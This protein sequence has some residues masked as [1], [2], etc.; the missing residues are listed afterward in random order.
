VFVRVIS[1]IVYST[2]PNTQLRA[3]S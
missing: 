2:E 3:E 1:W